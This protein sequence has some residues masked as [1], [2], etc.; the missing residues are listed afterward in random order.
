MK[1]V[2]KDKFSS[3][4]DGWIRSSTIAALFLAV[5]F[6]HVIFLFESDIAEWVDTLLK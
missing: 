2:L 1:D 4:L 3:F 5:F 6:L